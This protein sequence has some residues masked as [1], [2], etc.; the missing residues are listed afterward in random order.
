MNEHDTLPPPFPDEVTEPDGTS[1]M[2]LW[3]AA[4]VED[5]DEPQEPENHL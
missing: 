5:D 2:K 4:P 3:A 1:L